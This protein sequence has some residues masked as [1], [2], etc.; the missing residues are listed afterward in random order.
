MEELEQNKIFLRDLITDGLG[1]ISPIE[2]CRALNVIVSIP[3]ETPF[4]LSRDESSE[5]YDKLIQDYPVLEN[6]YYKKF[7][8]LE[9]SLPQD[10][11]N[12]LKGLLQWLIQELCIWDEAEDKNAKRLSLVLIISNIL[13]ENLWELIPFSVI[14]N[15]KIND[16][17]ANRFNWFQCNIVIPQ[18]RQ[19]PIWEKEAAQQYMEAIKE[20]NWQHLANNWYIWGNSPRLE[21][22]NTFQYQIFLFLLNY[23]PEQLVSATDQYEDFISL[24]LICR[25]H[26]FSLFQRLQLA[27]DTTNEFFRFI[28]LFSLELNNNKYNGLTD[29]EADCFARIFQKIGCDIH[30][31]GHW[32]IIFNRYP[33]RFPIFAE[34]FG[35]YVAKYASESDM[36]LYLESIKVEAI[37]TQHGYYDTR[38]ILGKTF[39]KLAEVADGN[40]RKLFWS[41]CYCKWL[42]WNF[43][44]AEEHYHL[45]TVHLSNIDYALV[46]YFIECQ[47]QGDR[48]EV[49]QNILKDVDSIFTKNWYGSQSGITTEF[50]NLLSNLQPV[51]YAG[52]VG[53]VER[54][55]W[56]M[57]PERVYYPT[58][59][60]TDE[61]Y[62]MAFSFRDI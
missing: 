8:G 52:E 56:L 17:L 54:T 53:E 58:I 12:V 55:S 36:D 16:F 7:R 33:V 30:Q 40:V 31:L 1:A 37:N 49:V 39:H 13:M 45:S 27:L 61:R 22:A 59:F 46:G 23:S 42:A 26:S 34:G 10:E 29:A 38:Q 25:E 6:F 21:Q 24:M 14:N 35:V 47:E 3:E 19:V 48:E 60:Q 4:N 2:P 50:Y 28:L 20:R 57:K 5:V 62:R 15:T 43:G 51:C 44:Q 9:N 41:K 11:R 32:L 18:H